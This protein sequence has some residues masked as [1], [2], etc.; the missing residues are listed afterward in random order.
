MKRLLRCL[1]TLALVLMPLMPT[2]MTRGISQ[3]ALAADPYCLDANDQAFLKLIN[4]Y[5]IANQLSPLTPSPTLGT[6]AQLHSQDMAVNDYSSHT[7]LDGSSP[8]DRMNRAGYPTSQAGSWGENIYWGS[9]SLGTPQ[10]AFNWWRNSPGHNAN[11]LNP[12]FRAIGI[13]WYHSDTYGKTHWTNT[14]GGRVDA[15]AVNCGGGPTTPPTGTVNPVFSGSQATVLTS[16]ATMNSAATIKTRDGDTASNWTSGS[17]PTGQVVITLDLGRERSVTG[18]KWMTAYNGFADQFTVRLMNENYGSATLG[19]FTNPGSTRT[20]YGVATAPKTARWVKLY[21]DNPNNDYVVGSISEIQVFA[22]DTANNP[23]PPG[24]P[25]PGFAGNELRVTGISATMNSWAAPLMVDSSLTSNWTSGSRPSGTVTVT[26]DLGADRDITG[27]KWMT[28]YLGYMDKFTIN[29]MNT[30]YQSTTLGTF[31]NPTAS[32]VYHGVSVNSPVRGRWVKIYIENPNNDYVV[33]SIGDISVFGYGGSGASLTAQS[34]TPEAMASPVASP[35][36][37]P[38]VNAS[39]VVNPELDTAATPVTVPDDEQAA[40]ASPEAVE[41]VTTDPGDDM[42]ASPE[43]VESAPPTEEQGGASPEVVEPGTEQIPTLEPTATE[44]VEPTVTVE[45]TAAVSQG[46]ISGTDGAVVNC[47]V[48]PVDGEVIAGL[49]EGTIIEVTGPAEG[50]WY[51]VSCAGQTGY[52]SADF[53]T[54]GTPESGPD[55]TP[56]ATEPVAGDDGAASP[57][58]EEP[59]ATA[60]EPVEAEDVPYPVVDT[61]DTEQS[62]A[63]WLAS[64]NDPGTWWTAVP[65]VNPEQVRL[66]FD[67]GSVVPIDHLTINLATWDQLPN[68]EIWLSEDAGTWFNAT[69]G[70]INGWNLERDVDV[71]IDLGFDARYVRIVI[72]NADESGLGE[73][74]GIRQVN[75]WPGDINATQYLT[76][77]GN[78]TTPE[79]ALV[80]PTAT[81]EPEPTATEVVEEGIE[82]TATREPEEVFEPTA[83]ATTAPVGD[84]SGELPPDGG[85][86]PQPGEA[87]GTPA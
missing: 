52:V 21:F 50:G 46:F 53:V 10:S 37:S 26:V 75:I 8:A 40:D 80:E 15:T 9:G 67:L 87:E 30:S 54:L 82:P 7:G 56:T 39:P 49:E 36:A 55:P 16:T 18:V 66:Y 19:T 64:D 76:A 23:P 4:D 27:V 17:R 1:A 48:S 5:R 43:V 25:R 32:G 86:L 79:P 68:F 22:S 42:A 69:P 38:E 81:T 59:T 78:P 14:F 41:P 12:N 71:A 20:W 70:G 28:A 63:A 85:D 74:G 6:A 45:P 34:A 58:A 11:M 77:L 51:Q 84:D 2:P 57:D 72:P 44:S 61:G 60:T 13:G 3:I 24:Y 31:G 83:T 65:S 33:G 73:V 62:G 35:V 29:V 47:R